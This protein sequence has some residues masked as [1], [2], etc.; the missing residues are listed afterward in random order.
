MT[1][2]ML[3]R[4]AYSLIFLRQ[5]SDCISYFLTQFGYILTV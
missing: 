3:L 5:V 1:C 2:N 4:F